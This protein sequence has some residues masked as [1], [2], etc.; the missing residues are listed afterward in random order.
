MATETELKLQLNAADVD[1][2]RNHSLLKAVTASEP[3]VLLNTYYDS[4]DLLLAGARVALRLRRQGER[5]IQTLKTSGH[6]VNGLH[7]RGEWEWELVQPVLDM[8]KLSGEI[9]PKSL[10]PAEQLQLLP[11]F[12]TDFERETWQVCFQGAEIEVAL[13]QGLKS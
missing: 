2:F 11:V 13:D 1:A 9:W 10:P 8:Q 7:Q 3:S 12:T 5:I 6:S 4:A